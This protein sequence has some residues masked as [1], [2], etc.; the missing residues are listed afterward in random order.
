MCSLQIKRFLSSSSFPNGA[1]AE[2]AIRLHDEHSSQESRVRTCVFG[3]WSLVWLSAPMRLRQLKALAISSAKSFL[4]MPSSPVKSSEPVVRPVASKRRSESFTSSLPMRRENIK[5][6]RKE[7]SAKEQR[8]LSKENQFLAVSPPA[9]SSSLFAATALLFAQESPLLQ[10]RHHNVHHQLLCFLHGIAR[11][12]DAD[13]I[14][15]T[16]GYFQISIKIGRASC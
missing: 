10:E 7:P 9:L 13:A 14:R 6:K 2:R 1:K 5:A 16:I 12:D 3:L 15:I 4:P 11:V 8:A